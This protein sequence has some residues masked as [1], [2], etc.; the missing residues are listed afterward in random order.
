M[1]KIMYKERMDDYTISTMDSVQASQKN[2]EEISK[3]LASVTN[4]SDVKDKNN[5]I[6]WGASLKKSCEKMFIKPSK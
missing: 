2:Y 6:R 4:K 5:L 3:Y 1:I